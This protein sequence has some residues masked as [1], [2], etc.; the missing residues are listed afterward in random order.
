MTFPVRLDGHGMRASPV[1]AHVQSKGCE[2]ECK[3]GVFKVWLP[4]DSFRWIE[5]L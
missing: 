1:G 3:A 5:G 4:S 2:D